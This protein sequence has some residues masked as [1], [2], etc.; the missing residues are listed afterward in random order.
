MT[1]ANGTT[2]TN[3][4]VYSTDNTKVGVYNLQIKAKFNKN[5]VYAV[6]VNFTLTVKDECYLTQIVITGTIANQNY[7]IKIPPMDDVVF[8]FATWNDTLNR[9]GPLTYAATLVNNS[10]L[11]DF[12]QF[13]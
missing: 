11:P 9:C 5:S 13:D 3:I 8:A 10:E 7:T 12:I 4:S 1:F 6:Q 2:N